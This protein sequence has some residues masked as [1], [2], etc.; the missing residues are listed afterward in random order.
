MILLAD[1]FITLGTL[2]HSY[3]YEQNHPSHLD[4]GFPKEAIVSSPGPHA[5]TSR[6]LDLRAPGLREN[7]SN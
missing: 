6:D 7:N 1:F 2:A 3:L 5:K 4:R